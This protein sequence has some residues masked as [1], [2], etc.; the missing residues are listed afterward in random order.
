MAGAVAGRELLAVC[1]DER[2]CARPTRHRGWAVW[3]R[4]S[5]LDVTLLEIFLDVSHTIYSF[6]MNLVG[7]N[8]LLLFQSPAV[9]SALP[10]AG[11]RG[12][13]DLV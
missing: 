7:P 12:S 11:R 5:C 1:R 3:R 9:Q 6:R 13:L 2:W 8:G 10:L 4:A